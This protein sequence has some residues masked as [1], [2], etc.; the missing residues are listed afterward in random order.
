MKTTNRPKRKILRTASYAC[1]ILISLCI[2]GCPSKREPAGNR[3]TSAASAIPGPRPAPGTLTEEL[4]AAAGDSATLRDVRNT[5]ILRAAITCNR[6]PLCFKDGYG[7]ARGFEADL[8]R[9]IASAFGVKL[10]IVPPGRPAAISGPFQTKPEEQPFDLITYY[11][12]RKT[13]WL[14]FRAEGDP[15]FRKAVALAISHLYDTGTYQQLFL[16]SLDP[17]Q[18]AGKASRVK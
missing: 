4:N 15:G 14:A 2:S 12:S 1:L 10:N 13:G 18:T 5:G 8:L 11:Y 3:N 16:N 7:V 17:A 6:P 9:Q